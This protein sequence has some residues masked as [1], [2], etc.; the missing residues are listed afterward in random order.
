MKTN[1]V[2]R[3]LLFGVAGHTCVVMAPSMGRFTAALLTNGG[4]GCSIGRLTGDVNNASA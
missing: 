3:L 2:F 1:V 4:V